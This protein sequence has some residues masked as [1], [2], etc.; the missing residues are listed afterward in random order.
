MEIRYAQ[1]IWTNRKGA[2]CLEQGTATRLAKKLETL[3]CLA[4]LWLLDE[5]GH[6]TEIVGGCEEANGQDDKRIKWNWWYDKTMVGLP[7]SPR[8]DLGR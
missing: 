1:L 5:E 6:K 2:G 8:E 7:D 4:D 3:R